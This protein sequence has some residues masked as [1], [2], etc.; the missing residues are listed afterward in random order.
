MKIKIS[1][2]KELTINAIK[3]KLVPMIHGSPAIG[4]SAIVHQIAE[5]FGLKLIDLRLSQ[6]DPTDLLGFPKITGDKAGYV[7]MDTFPIEGDPIPKGYNGW[8][9][10]LDELNSSNRSVQAAAYKLALDK[11][12]GQFNLHSN[13]A[14]VAAGNLEDDGAIVEP[15]ST[16][17]QSRLIHLEVETNAKDWLNWAYSENFDHRITSFIEFRNDKLYTFQSDH[18][19]KTYASPR[20]WAFC[21]RLTKVVDPGKDSI[22]LY[23]GTIGEGVAREFIGFCGLQ[24][25]LP[26]L[27]E[28]LSNPT[29]IKVPSEPS[30]QF[31]LVGAIAAQ[32]DENNT[33]DLLKFIA[34]LPAEFQVVCLRSMIRRHKALLKVPAVTEWLS[35]ASA[36]LM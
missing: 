9:L 35:K 33:T 20:T 30:V 22:A 1:E 17:L 29:G 3:A 15:M 36:E 7:P 21:N 16:A 27:S 12:V 8:L 14:I 34:R 11:K 6:C 31:A 10:F 18:T 24:E 4:K 13:V 26:K 28:I 19:D 5:E 32:A 23:A 25:Q 2:G